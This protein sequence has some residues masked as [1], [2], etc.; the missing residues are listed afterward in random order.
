MDADFA[1]DVEAAIESHDPPI[2]LLNLPP[3]CGKDLLTQFFQP[4]EIVMLYFPSGL[5]QLHGDLFKAVA[6]EQMKPQSLTLDL[7]ED[8]PY[9]A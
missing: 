9:V 7:G 8:S 5:V 1:K 4:P 2:I 3:A 6:L